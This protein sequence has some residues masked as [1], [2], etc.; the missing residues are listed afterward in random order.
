MKRSKN[1][2]RGEG[3]KISSAHNA[4]GPRGNVTKLNLL[5]NLYYYAYEVSKLV[6]KVDMKLT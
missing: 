2:G 4:N 1:G 5:V 3:E 6:Y